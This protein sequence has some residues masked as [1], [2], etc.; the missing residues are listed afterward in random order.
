MEAGSSFR[1]HRHM[2]NSPKPLINLL[3]LA[4]A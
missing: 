4:V 3:Y 2:L 1:K